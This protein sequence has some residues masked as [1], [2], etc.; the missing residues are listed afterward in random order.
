MKL[1]FHHIVNL[2]VVSCC[3]SFLF[4]FLIKIL[5]HLGRLVFDEEQPQIQGDPPPRHASAAI[6]KKYKVKGIESTAGE[7]MILSK[8]LIYEGPMSIWLPQLLA[9]IKTTIQEQLHVALGNEPR[10]AQ[11]EQTLRSTGAS[12]VRISRPSSAVSHKSGSSQEKMNPTP[13]QTDVDSSRDGLP[14]S[15]HDKVW[16]ARC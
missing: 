3:F 15:V 4:R 11:I 13:P 1:S 16:T 7:V 9:S 14:H 6:K 12:K 5:P 10:P 2:L 8:P